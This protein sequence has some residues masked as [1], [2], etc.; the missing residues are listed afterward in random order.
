MVKNSIICQKNSKYCC[1][2]AVKHSNV[3]M[4]LIKVSVY[5]AKSAQEKWNYLLHHRPFVTSYHDPLKILH[6]FGVF[7]VHVCVC[8]FSLSSERL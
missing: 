5:Y 6:N 4:N 8:F 7:S 1:C 2:L 3:V